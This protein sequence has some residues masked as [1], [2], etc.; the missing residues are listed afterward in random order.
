MIVMMLTIS[1]L[2]TLVVLVTLPLSIL[3]TTLI[4]KR[5]QTYFR[6]SAASAWRI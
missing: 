1:P 5:S 3:V 6:E 2:L 4:A